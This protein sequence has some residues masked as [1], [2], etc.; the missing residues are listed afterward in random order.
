[1]DRFKNG[2]QFLLKEFGYID[3]PLGM[4]QRIQRGKID[5]PLDGAPDVLRAIYSK[6]TNNR[7]VAFNGDCFFQI[8][9]WDTEGKIHS[10]SIHQYG[11]GTLDT[12]SIHF[13]DQSYLFSE[14]KMKTVWM[15]LDSIK[16]NLERSYI[17]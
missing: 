8:V 16:N 3:V 6:M 7:K 10:K 1:M 4:L 11:S 2:V 15:D 17:P 13:S 5:L 12:S 14:K 9:E